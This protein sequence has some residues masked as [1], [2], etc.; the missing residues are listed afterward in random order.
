MDN[1]TQPEGKLAYDLRQIYHNIC[2]L[3]MDRAVIALFESRWQDFYDALIDLHTLID[4]RINENKEPV[5]FDALNTNAVAVLNKYPRVFQNKESNAQAKTEIK[6]TLN[7]MLN[8]L[9]KKMKDANMF[10]NEY[11]ESA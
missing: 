9:L 7:D 11:Y 4:H 10:G 6:R 1:T 2:G 3:A 8:Y 5:K